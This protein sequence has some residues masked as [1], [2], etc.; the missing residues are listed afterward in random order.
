MSSIPSYIERFQLCRRTLGL[1]YAHGHLGTNFAAALR[2]DDLAPPDH[3]GPA[4]GS[5]GDDNAADGAMNAVPPGEVEANSP[6]PSPAS[7]PPM[8][9]PDC[10]PGLPAIYRHAKIFYVPGTGIYHVAQ[11]HHVRKRSRT[12]SGTM[13]HGWLC[14]C[15]V[16]VDDEHTQ[17]RSPLREDELSV[18]HFSPHC[19]RMLEYGEKANRYIRRCAQCL[20]V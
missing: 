12:T 17:V 19:L 1:L 18:W 3:S 20:S 11:C 16:S 6:S 7:E 4:S 2:A 10:A 14:S 8:D 15:S 13:R 9:L 5:H